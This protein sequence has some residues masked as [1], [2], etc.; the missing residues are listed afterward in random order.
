MKLT[1][2]QEEAIKLAVARYINKEPY[3]VIGGVAG[4]GK[5]ETVKYIISALNF[6][7]EQVA[8]IAYTGKAAKVLREKGCPNAMTAHKL[9]Y[10]SILM[11]NGLY[12]FVPLGRLEKLYKCIVVDEVSMLPKEMW[13]LLLTHKIYVIA[14]GDPEQL[15]PINPEENNHVLDNPHIF[16]TEI[17][18]QA[19]DSEIIRLATFIREGGLL[20]NYQCDNEQCMVIDK[21]D[22]T[23]QMILWAD[24]IICATNDTR[25]TLNHYVRTLK[26]YGEEPEIGDKIISL[27]NHWDI[28]AHDI[29]QTPL[30]NG[31]ILTIQQYGNQIIKVPKYIYENQFIPLMI[32][33]ASEDDTVFTGLIIDYNSIKNNAKT[34]NNKQEYLMK[35]HKTLID[36]PLEFA[37]GYALTCWKAQGS[38]W[39]KILGFEEGFPRERELHRRYL[40]TLCT[41]A[42]DRL[43]LVKQ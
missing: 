29:D 22:L 15:P 5:S 43:V 11:P 21:E 13:D 8:Y 30:T 26:G 28:L 31:T 18:R 32:T 38:Q 23:D 20:K 1:D 41:R 17:M 39:N 42:V 9:L 34:L 36:P 3:T 27:K 24:Q 6:L 10:K 33:T 40:Y 19:F 2:K 12:K 14:M 25:N 37:Y 4:T 16:L 35:K 7:P